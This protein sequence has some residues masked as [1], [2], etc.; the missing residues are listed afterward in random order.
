MSRQ[1]RIEPMSSYQL[2]RWARRERAEFMA[3]CL[4]SAAIYVAISFRDCVRYFCKER[5]D[6]SA[7]TP[8]GQWKS[9]ERDTPESLQ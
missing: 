6:W 7:Q 2:M 1:T 8:S 5:P 9:T 3:S 4:Q